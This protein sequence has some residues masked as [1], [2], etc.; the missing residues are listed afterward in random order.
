MGVFRA[1][2]RLLIV[3]LS[4]VSLA[5]AARI[6]P[7]IEINEN[8]IEESSSS[9][10]P[11]RNI[12]DTSKYGILQLNNGLAQ[13]PQ[14]GVFTCQVHPG[15]IYL[16]N[17][18]AE[19]FASW[20]VDYFRSMTTVTIWAFHQRKDILPMRDALNATGH[21]IF[22]LRFVKCM[23]TIADINDKWTSLY[24]AGGWNVGNGDMTFKGVSA[25][26]SIWAL[27]K[28][29]LSLVG[30]DARN[31]IV[32]KLLRFPTNKD[33]AGLL[34]T[35]IRLAFKGG[36]FLSKAVW[37]GPLSGNRLVVALWNR[38]SEAEILQAKCKSLGLESTRSASKRSG[39]TVTSKDESFK[40]S[41]SMEEI[42]KCADLQKQ[43]ILA[44]IDMV[45]AISKT[46]G[47]GVYSTCSMMIPK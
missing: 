47:Y 27:M 29:L 10:T 39:N 20:G 45:N 19:L 25:H 40:A 12:F 14:M 34:L 18:D 38:C 1:Q 44:S 11:S 3:C 17:D 31:M 6:V 43:V 24:G 32:Q 35:K 2:L 5:I 7:H 13:T 28:V 9:A 8:P 42:L 26:F 46:T 37:A 4:L 41:K 30:C 23:T 21:K 36:R 22:Y 15:S 16:E 33:T